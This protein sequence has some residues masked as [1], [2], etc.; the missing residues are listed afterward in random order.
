MSNPVETLNWKGQSRREGWRALIYFPRLLIRQIVVVPLGGWSYGY[1]H[2]HV[3]LTT[4]LMLVITNWKDL[5]SAVSPK[6]FRLAR[7]FVVVESLTTLHG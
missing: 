4:V 7:I 1:H 5:C 2:Y 6:D 3:I